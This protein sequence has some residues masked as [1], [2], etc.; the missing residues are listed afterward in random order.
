MSYL[1]LGKPKEHGETAAVNLELNGRNNIPWVTVKGGVKLQAG[2]LTKNN[3]KN[4]IGL[5]IDTLV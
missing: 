1:S 3:Y 5:E 2:S 4:Y